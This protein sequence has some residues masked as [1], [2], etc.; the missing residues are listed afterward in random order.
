MIRHYQTWKGKLV[1]GSACCRL[2]WVGSKETTRRKKN[3]TC[4][5]CVRTKVYRGIK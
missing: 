5:N 1:V 4:G 3:V 2:F